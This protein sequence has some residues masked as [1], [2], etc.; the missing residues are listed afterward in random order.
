MSAVILDHKLD[1]LD[2]ELEMFTWKWKFAENV[3]TIRTDLEKIS[4]TSLAQQWILCSEW[5]PS[6]WESKQLI[7]TSQ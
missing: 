5:V 3:L 2:L 6:E 7:K 1:Q 4:I